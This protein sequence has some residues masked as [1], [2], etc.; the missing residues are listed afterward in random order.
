MVAQERSLR[1]YTRCINR[2]QKQSSKQGGL[3]LG[4]YSKN[5]ELVMNELEPVNR[6]G[7]KLKPS[8]KLQYFAALVR[9]SEAE[10]LTEAKEKYSE[11]LT[12]LNKMI[13]M[14]EEKGLRSQKERL[15]YASP[16]ELEA[17]VALVYEKM[18][19]TALANSSPHELK[20]YALAA[21][22]WA[23]LCNPKR[24]RVL[25]LE[26]RTCY[27]GNVNKTIYLN[28]YCQEENSLILKDYKTAATYGT[29]TIQ[30]T[31]LQG[32]IIRESLALYPRDFL[33]SSIDDPKKPMDQT[34]LTRLLQG[35]WMLD[36]ERRP[37]C[38][39]IRSSYITA[40][41]DGR[42]SLREQQLFARRSMTSVRM[43]QLCYDK[44]DNPYH[45]SDE[46]VGPSVL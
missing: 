25:R 15:N 45:S 23:V 43:L 27:V 12:K 28:R 1:A 18:C 41:M 36:S 14:E 19:G 7:Q 5:I 21:A 34:V 46:S 2:L 35:S 4:D 9:Y 11:Q 16:D 37:S 42:P 39:I 24:D 17:N 22:A 8:S 33:V 31:E 26:M 13:V 40:F 38:D 3:K 30:L 44:P 6:P 32:K 10:G 29:Q 20:K